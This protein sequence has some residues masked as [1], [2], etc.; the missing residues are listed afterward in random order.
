M[1][2]EEELTAEEKLQKQKDDFLHMIADCKH[3]ASDLDTIV[4]GAKGILEQEFR[5]KVLDVFSDLLPHKDYWKGN[6]WVLP[7][8]NVCKDLTDFDRASFVRECYFN[9][10][11]KDFLNKHWEKIGSIMLLLADEY[12]ALYPF[13]AEQEARKKADAAEEESEEKKNG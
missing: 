8:H 9:S 1:S 13:Y 10:E 4:K 2:K 7:G 12:K 5:L 11:Q 6:D 3:D